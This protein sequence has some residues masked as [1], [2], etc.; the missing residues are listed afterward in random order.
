ML[1]DA[2]TP[3]EFIKALPE[4]RRSVI[5]K[6][7]TT[8]RQ[9]LPRGFKETMSYGMLAY[10]VPLSR[11]PTGYHCKPET[12]LPFVSLASQKNYIA[13]YHMGLYADKK[14]LSWFQAEYAKRVESRLDMGKSCIRFKKP[15]QIPYDLIAELAAKI[16]PQEWTARYESAVKR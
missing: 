4:E 2:A 8:L 15:D 12:P 5:R 3:A 6:I 7:R 14:M 11:Y 16:T 13:L 10:V 1:S 9:S